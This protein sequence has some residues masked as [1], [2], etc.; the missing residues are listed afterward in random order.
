M[1]RLRSSK[2]SAPPDAQTPATPKSPAANGKAAPP[3]SASAGRPIGELLVSEGTIT[4][5]ELQSALLAQD[6]SGRRLGTELVA[7]DVIDEFQLASALA[8]QFG[9]PVA[10]LSTESPVAEAVAMLPEA[11][12]RDNNAIP[13][14]LD[15]GM[16]HIAV[17]DPLPEVQHRI[18]QAVGRTVA[19]AVA[20]AN[21]I[22]RAVDSAYRAL[23]DV[24]RYVDAFQADIA[25]RN[26]PDESLM[27]KA[28]ADAPVVRIVDMILT[29]ALRDRASDI[30][31]EPQ[32][33]AVRVRYRIDGAL[34]EVLN[35]PSK[36]APAV[37]S[38]LKIMAGMN[39]VERRRPQDGQ[40][41]TVIDGRE[42]DLRVSTL[43]TIWGEKAVLRLLDKSKPL[44][45]MTDLGMPPE[46]HEM[47]AKMIRSPFGM[48][49]CAGPTGSGKTTT[50]YAS[51]S[52]LNDPRRNIMTIE[53]PVE[54]VFP[55]INQIQTNDQTGLTF[56]QGLK[57]ILRQ[58]PDVILV[59]EIRDVD[60]AR[61]AV[62]SALTG[63]T[64]L[65]S[66]HATDAVAALHRFLDMGIES[67][68]IASSVVGIIGQRL[69][70]R[71]CTSCKEPYSPPADELSFFKDAGGKDKK[72]F[73]RGT[74]CNFCSDTGYQ[75]RIGV[76]EV[77]RITP[78]IRRLVVGWATQEE[79][80][81]VA[82]AQGM[83]TLQQEAIR[84]VEDD[85]TTIDEV[86]RSI[87]AV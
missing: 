18:T 45:K 31:I 81:R 83:R 51:L 59:G 57:S 42:L 40:I 85:I 6:S 50:L 21:D 62:Q 30:H 78:E 69:V 54:F 87:Y 67:F 44:Y 80:Q 73:F 79:L 16:L 10:D 61:I 66:L 84:L 13:L 39:I 1:A 49:L 29:Q 75:D 53:D 3:P 24:A 48:V 4:A 35:L 36:I 64:V 33:D 38:R 46:T 22:R 8:S 17:A 74:G 23:S 7:L 34:H 26:L 55:S 25:D 60:T 56:A 5:E 32:G 11:I 47:L 76:F 28:G 77:L 43:S 41:V 19:F 63:H 15:N 68:L 86:V 14:R 2:R 72:Q 52:E 12:A 71:T 20:P 9:L 58:D 65:S 27:A 82:V 37:V 70:R